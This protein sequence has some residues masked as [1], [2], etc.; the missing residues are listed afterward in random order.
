MKNEAPQQKH[1]SDVTTRDVSHTNAKSKH[2][3]PM[4]PP[5]SRPPHAL[6]APLCTLTQPQDG[7][8]ASNISAGNKVRV[9]LVGPNDSSLP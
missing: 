8:L 5:S 1:S 2:T 4:P 9:V 6:R 3:P 7:S